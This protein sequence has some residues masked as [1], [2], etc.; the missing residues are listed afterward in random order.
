MNSVNRINLV[1]EQ[2]RCLNGYG[3]RKAE[4]MGVTI[5]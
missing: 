3:E 1:F 5:E 2:L 4:R